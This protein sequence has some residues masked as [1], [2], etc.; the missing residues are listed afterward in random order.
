ML[1]LFHF[2]SVLA[3]GSLLPTP[4]DG[5]VTPISFRVKR[6]NLRGILAEFDEKETGERE[7]SGE[8][9]TN[10]RLWKKMTRE[11]MTESKASG[12]E[13]KAPTTPIE[14]GRPTKGSGGDKNGMV[15]LY[16]HGGFVAFFT[17]SLP[18]PF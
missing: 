3:L 12:S 1:T 4:K 17:V 14:N 15:C 10:K 7:I 16:L 6:R 8:W 18:F 11:W 5:I 13:A 9:V 2:R